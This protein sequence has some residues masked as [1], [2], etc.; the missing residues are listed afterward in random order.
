MHT[1]ATTSQAA[2]TGSPRVSATIA[3]E[4]APSTA[5]P[6]H[7]SF[8]WNVIASLLCIGLARV[9]QAWP[10]CLGQSHKGHQLF[11]IT[12]QPALRALIWINAA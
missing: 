11:P 5:T 10:G 7:N 4:I 3:N 9:A 2:F 12:R 8:A 6:A 1:A